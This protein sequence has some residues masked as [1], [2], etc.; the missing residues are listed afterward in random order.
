MHDALAA[1]GSGDSKVA[2]YHVPEVAALDTSKG[3]DI[4]RVKSPVPLQRQ[5][6][7]EEHSDS[8]YGIE[9]SLADPWIFASLSY[10]GHVVVNKVPRNLKYKVL[11]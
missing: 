7:L 3:A 2:L 5:E 6:T 9:W 8:V 1:S 4:S 10:D 11:V